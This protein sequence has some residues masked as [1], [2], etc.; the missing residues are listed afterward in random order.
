MKKSLHFIHRPF[1]F[2]TSLLK[3][4][5]G[6]QVVA[7]YFSALN[8]STSYGVYFLTFDFDLYLH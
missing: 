8:S 1:E 3:C 2:M 6:P 5:V 4:L 7:E